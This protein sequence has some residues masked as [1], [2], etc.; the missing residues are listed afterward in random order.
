MWTWH[1]RRYVPGR[2]GP[3][4][5]F[6]A[7]LFLRPEDAAK[8]DLEFAT[9]ENFAWTITASRHWLFLTDTT[10]PKS[11]IFLTDGV[12]PDSLPDFREVWLLQDNSAAPEADG[13]W[14]EALSYDIRFQK[15]SLLFDA[16][17]SGNYLPAHWLVRLS[18]LRF[19]DIPKLR[20]ITT[21]GR[22]L[23]LTNIAFNDTMANL[24]I[25]RNKA[26]LGN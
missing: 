13:N 8:L 2:D 18:P 6:M 22:R 15:W 26:L 9:T 5:M 4:K 3:P 25:R 14:R 11:R 21:Y 1:E 16:K 10:N 20:T 17:L 19:V 24:I 7:T 12:I 23:V